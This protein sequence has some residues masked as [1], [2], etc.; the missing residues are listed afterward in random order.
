MV[1]WLRACAQRMVVRLLAVSEPGRAVCKALQ[2]WYSVVQ[3]LTVLKCW[4]STAPD[5]VDPRL[6]TCIARGFVAS[7]AP[8]FI[9]SLKACFAGG[10]SNALETRRNHLL[11][12][13]TTIEHEKALHTSP[14]TTKLRLNFPDM[15]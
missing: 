5:D 6:A 12:I 2:W 11:A 9:R 4:P 7:A 3:Y 1:E 15:A 8:H 14:S 10:V 13:N